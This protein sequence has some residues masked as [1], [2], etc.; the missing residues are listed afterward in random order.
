MF[1]KREKSYDKPSVCKKDAKLFSKKSNGEAAIPPSISE[2]TI[3]RVL[4][5]AGLIWTHF[6]ILTK[7]D[8]KLRLTFP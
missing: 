6:Q 1:D 8:L 2:E 4:L 5:K 3:Y 7:S